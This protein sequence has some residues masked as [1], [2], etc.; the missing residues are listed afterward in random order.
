MPKGNWKLRIDALEIIREY[1]PPLY[2]C[3]FPP[4]CCCFFSLFSPRLS[5]ARA[6]VY[7]FFY[8]PRVL[9]CRRPCF[10]VWKI[11]ISWTRA[12]FYYSNIFH[13]CA[14][15]GN[16]HCARARMG[17]K[18]FVRSAE[19]KTCMHID[20]PVFLKEIS[21]GGAAKLQWEISFQCGRARAYTL[22]APQWC[23]RRNFGNEIDSARSVVLHYLFAFKNCGKFRLLF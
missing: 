7:N 23:R 12:L 6:A 4:R 16:L 14:P 8:R 3:P 1:S 13:R 10:A 20:V 11:F 2:M 15:R 17:G 21:R 19:K 22:T 18:K 9:T 5:H